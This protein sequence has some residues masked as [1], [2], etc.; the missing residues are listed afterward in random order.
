MQ[1]LL[2][3]RKRTVV[4]LA[5]LF[6]VAALFFTSRLSAHQSTSDLDAVW[7]RVQR[8]GAYHFSADVRQT[9]TPPATVG[10]AG[11]SSKETAMHME[12]AADPDAESLHLTMWTSGGS[13]QDPASGAEVRRDR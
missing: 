2:K 6:A 11:R 8:A 9:S 4:V 13:V 12:G 3:W 5:T 1:D 7:A 10:N